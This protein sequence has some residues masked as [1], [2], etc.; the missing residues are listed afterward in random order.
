MKIEVKVYNNDKTIPLPEYKTEFSA[1][2][3]LHADLS[4]FL[5]NPMGNGLYDFDQTEYKLSLKPGGRVLIS[6]GLQVKIPDGY[7]I[8]IRPRSGLALKNGIT[9]VNSPATIDSDY[10]GVIGIILLNCGT[11]F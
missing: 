3:D 7:E 10:T 9:I 8:Q 11:N 5:K 6:S 4:N 1:G 2:L